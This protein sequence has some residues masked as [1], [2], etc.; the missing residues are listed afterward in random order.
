MKLLAPSLARG[1][2]VLR[3]L[4]DGSS[5]TLEGIVRKTRL[6]RTSVFRILDT[7]CHLE[8]VRKDAGKTY[9]AQMRF[10]PMVL[11]GRGFEEAVGASMARLATETGQTVEWYVPMATGH[12]VLTRRQDPPA[13]ATRVGSEVGGIIGTYNEFSPVY[14]VALAWSGKA[15][16]GLGG[17]W[18]Y[19]PDR[20]KRKVSRA[21]ATQTLRQVR[22]NGYA[23]QD[24]YNENWV[25]RAACA[26]LDAKSLVGVL[27][28]ALCYTPD[29]AKKEDIYLQAL[30]R[31]SDG[32]SR[33]HAFLRKE[34]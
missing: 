30:I 4:E 11:G 6:P 25:K 14:Q 33:N 29:L 22:E 17:L 18:A 31:Q 16:S 21:E 10:V 13:G 2:S 34:G 32:L 20:A 3:T 8:M 23:V 15:S 27:A 28:L 1:I 7:L 5:L 12:V 26:V 9:S 19:G 24:N